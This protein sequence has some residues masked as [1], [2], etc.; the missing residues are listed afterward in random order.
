MI[1]VVE[2]PTLC[3]IIPIDE[4][5]LILKFLHHHKLKRIRETYRTLILSSIYIFGIGY[6][7]VENYKMYNGSNQVA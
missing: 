1:Q 3:T 2:Y 6:V 4:S 7:G 5:V